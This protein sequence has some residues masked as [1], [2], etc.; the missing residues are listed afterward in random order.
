V[1]DRATSWPLQ[2]KILRTLLQEC[3]RYDRF[4]A[5]SQCIVV[6]CHMCAVGGSSSEIESESFLW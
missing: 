4:A 5:V 1:F 2:S 3:L 6:I